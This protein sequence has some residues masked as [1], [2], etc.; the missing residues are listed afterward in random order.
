L[1]PLIAH[2]RIRHSWWRQCTQ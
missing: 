1:I 2:D